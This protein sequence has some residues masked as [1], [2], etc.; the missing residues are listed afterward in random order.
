[1]FALLLVAMGVG[2]SPGKV[3]EPARVGQIFLVGNEVTPQGLILDRLQL[4]PGQVLTDKD[5]RAAQQRLGWLTPLGIVSSASA[6]DDP[7]EP[8]F[9]DIRV[10][11]TETP[12][13]YVL[14]GVPKTILAR[15]YGW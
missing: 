8:V 6:L 5:L 7:A 9:K 4:Y 10:K 14:V 15:I 3:E 13:T 12:L 1:M 11:V 2:E